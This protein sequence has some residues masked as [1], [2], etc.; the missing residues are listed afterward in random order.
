M[1]LQLLLLAI[2]TYERAANRIRTEAVPRYREQSVQGRRLL[3]E[4]AAWNVA[5]EAPSPGHS[6][7][8]QHPRGGLRLFA[9]ALKNLKA[10]VKQ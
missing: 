10:R 3:P 2:R 6:R 4:A 9:L 7:L 1:A 5:D 8:Q